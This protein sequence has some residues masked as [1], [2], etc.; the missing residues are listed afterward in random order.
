MNFALYYA[1]DA[2]STAAKIMGRQS[3]GRSMMKGL[4]RTWPEGV[5]AGVGPGAQGGRSMLAQ[6][7]ADGF[8]GGVRW[9]QLPDM[10]AAVEAGTVYYPSP[11]PGELLHL[12]NRVQPDAFSVM[13]VT[14]TLSSND[15]L[16]RVAEWVLPP[17]RPWDAL[18]CISDCAK[19]LALQLQA[20]MRD[21]WGA[22]AGSMRFNTSQ[23]PVIPLGVDVPFFA[24]Q[25]AQRASAR[26]ALGIRSEEVAFL[27]SGRLSFHAKANPAALYRAL[28]QAAQRSPVVCVE[29]GIFPNEAIAQAFVAAQKALAPTVRFIHVHGRDEECY[30]QAWQAADVFASLADNI[31]ETFG[32]TPVEAMAAGLPVIVADWNGYKETIRDGVDGFRIPTVLP[33]AGVGEDLALRHALEEDSYDRYIGRTSMAT[34]VEPRALALAVHRLATDSA[35]RQEMGAAGLQR[36]QQVFDWPVV[37]RQYVA[38]AAELAAIRAQAAP[39][40][41]APRAWPQRADPFARFAHFASATLRG[42]WPVQALPDASARLRLLLD[43]SMANYVLDPRVLSRESLAAVLAVLQTDV[44]HTVNSVLQAAGQASP[45]GMRALMWLWKFDLVA[46]AAPGSDSP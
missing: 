39:H 36:A 9:S 34:V 44:A 22:Q 23:L 14:Y 29:A 7:Q 42:D 33:P 3:A 46:V 40:E 18:I 21:W 45:A 13:A 1:G 11:G 31:Q 2:Y 28:E 38:L 17:H 20:E 12:R 5:V 27:F 10:R 26:E 16:D 4:A 43:L 25:P 19:T 30:R 15:A 35:L 37:L 24:P 8:S 41:K 32:L 6:L